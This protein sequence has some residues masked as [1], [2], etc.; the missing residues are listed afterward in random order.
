M[1]WGGDIEAGCKVV[2]H[3]AAGVAGKRDDLVLAVAAMIHCSA[4]TL[5]FL[6]V[7]F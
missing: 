1:V 6:P 7:L 4:L 3:D 2:D 5:R